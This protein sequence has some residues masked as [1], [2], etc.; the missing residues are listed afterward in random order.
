MKFCF[1]GEPE[2]VLN[3]KHRKRR[4]S[5][6][7]CVETLAL[8]QALGPCSKG[9]DLMRKKTGS[10][11]AGRSYEELMEE[12]EEHGLSLTIRKDRGDRSVWVQGPGVTR[13][14]SDVSE[15]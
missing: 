12:A 4:H 14:L 3:L 13:S 10:S 5:K 6:R 8:L 1:H 2:M 15:D 11:R 9:L 7:R